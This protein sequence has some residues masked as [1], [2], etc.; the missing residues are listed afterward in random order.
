MSTSNDSKPAD[1]NGA[2]PRGGQEALID[3]ARV[4]IAD[5]DYP[6]AAIIEELAEL[7]MHHTA[8]PAGGN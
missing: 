1:R 2:Q 7:L 5:A 8:G 4:L 3:R 6:T